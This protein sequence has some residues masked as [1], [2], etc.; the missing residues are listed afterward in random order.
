ME[1]RRYKGW[2]L[3]EGWFILTNLASLELAIKAYKRRFDIEEMFR[4]FK[5]GVIT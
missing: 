5:R 2:T 1:K 3:E 4:D